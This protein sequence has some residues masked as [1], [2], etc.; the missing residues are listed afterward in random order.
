MVE[1]IVTFSNLE[2]ENV[3]N[4]KDKLNWHIQ[5]NR[6]GKYMMDRRRYILKIKNEFIHPNKLPE[7]EWK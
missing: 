5:D 1:H 3:I 7:D 2:N 4:P 6:E